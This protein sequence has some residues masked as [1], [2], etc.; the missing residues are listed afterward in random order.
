MHRYKKSGKRE[1]E[2][3]PRSKL[4]LPPGA[5]F[6]SKRP[7]LSVEQVIEYSELFLPILNAQPDC[8]ERRLRTKCRVPFRILP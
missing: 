4:N 7:R 3:L 8:E 1:G 2:I 5:G 6:R